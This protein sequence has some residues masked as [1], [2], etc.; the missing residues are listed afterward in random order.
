MVTLQQMNE[1]FKDVK[2]TENLHIKLKDYE[3]PVECKWDI[4][5]GWTYKINSNRINITASTC[6]EIEYFVTKENY[7]EYFL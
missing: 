7:P 3:Y 1:F 4:A 5:T 6:N 2:F